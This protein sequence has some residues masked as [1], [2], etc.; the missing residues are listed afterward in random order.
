MDGVP[1]PSPPS[2]TPSFPTRRQSLP[3]YLLY[4]VLLSTCLIHLILTQS[5]QLVH[6]PSPLPP[7]PSHPGTSS[8]RHRDRSVTSR[9]EIPNVQY[10]VPLQVVSSHS[11]PHTLLINSLVLLALS[12]SSR[13]DSPISALAG[14]PYPLPSLSSTGHSPSFDRSIPLVVPSRLLTL[15]TCTVSPSLTSNGLPYSSP[16]VHLPYLCILLP[17]LYFLGHTIVGSSLRMHQSS[18]SIHTGTVSLPSALITV[19]P[20]FTQSSISPPPGTVSLP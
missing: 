16:T 11:L 5:Q 10:S 15:P 2:F 4:T 14:I 1:P 6:T 13:V 7:S 18:Q 3:V 9:Q 19:S 8:D 20:L 17:I 12:P